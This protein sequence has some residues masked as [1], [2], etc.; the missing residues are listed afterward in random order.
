MY[1]L[2]LYLILYLAI[3]IMKNTGKSDC[4]KTACNCKEIFH[5]QV[6][7]MY[8]I[9][10]GVLE[11]IGNWF[12]IIFKMI[13]PALVMYRPIKTFIF[14]FVLIGSM[15]GGN[16][17]LS[18]DLGVVGFGIIYGVFALMLIFLPKAAS[19]VE[20]FLIAWYFVF[21]IVVSNSGPNPLFPEGMGE[22][23]QIYSDGLAWV[24]VFLL[25]KILFYFFIR[26]NNFEYRLKKN[27][28]DQVILRS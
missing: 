22:I 20:F 25:G 26:A 3:H 27:R 11:R 12:G 17:Y 24:I 7:S 15:N 28:D 18:T 23:L 10:S 1:A 21:L 13:I 6:Q 2:I 14:S 5:R 9:I 19:A 8:K 4:V 16:S